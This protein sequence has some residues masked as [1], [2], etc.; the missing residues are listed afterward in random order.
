MIG[1]GI[2]AMAGIFFALEQQN[3]HP[4]AYQ[5]RVTFILYVMVILGGAGSIWGPVLGAAMFNFIFFGTDEL[6]AQLQANVD[7]VGEIFSPAEAGLVKYVLLGLALML[8]MIFRPQG[9]LRSKEEG[10]AD[11][12]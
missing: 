10:R 3:V 4:D 5:P 7:W 8:L 1:G 12:L 6:M 2:A 9:M 11:A